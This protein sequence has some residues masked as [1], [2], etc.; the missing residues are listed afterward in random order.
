MIQQVYSNT[1]EEI[2]FKESCCVEHTSAGCY[3]QGVEECVCTKEAQCCSEQWS[4]SCVNYV[5]SLGC[6][7][8]NTGPCCLPHSSPSCVDRSTSNCVC[9]TDK[10]CCQY[11]WNSTCVEL[12]VSLGCTSC[13][14][15]GVGNSTSCCIPHQS[16]GC[17][18]KNVQQCV[19]SIDFFCCD[20]SWDSNCVKEVFEFD[21]F[22]GISNGTWNTVASMP[23]ARWGLAAAAV[24]GII[25]AIG[26]YNGNY[27]ST[28]QAYRIPKLIC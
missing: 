25:Y 3:D 28:V 4:E 24:N 14:T 12:A 1:D 6:G 10:S 19:C 9:K 26:G 20:I 13:P 21:C 8:C 16:S 2:Y 18:N 7:D 23:T 11:S 27:L 5:E 15:S 22:P 17:S